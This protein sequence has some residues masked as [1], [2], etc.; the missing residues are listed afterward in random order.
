MERRKFLIG[1]GALASGSAAAV[2]TGA[3]SSVEATRS[4]DVSTTGDTSAYL[5]FDPTVGKNSEFASLDG[6]DTVTVDINSA[7]RDAKTTILELFN[8][9][10]TGNSDVVVFINPNSVT[11]ESAGS[12]RSYPSPGNGEGEVIVDPQASNMPNEDEPFSLTGVY[13]SALPPEIADRLKNNP[14]GS[15][16]VNEETAGNNPGTSVYDRRVPS[17]TSFDFGLNIQH[18]APAEFPDNIS[19]TLSAIAVDQL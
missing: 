15:T 7:N 10:N 6:V 8:V 12:G 17:G 3:F 4:V 16:S 9:K 19:F 18:E 1:A 5:Q 2:G 14:A 13:G 11:P